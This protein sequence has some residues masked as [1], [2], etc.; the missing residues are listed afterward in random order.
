MILA[1]VFGQAQVMQLEG[2][3]CHGYRGRKGVVTTVTRRREKGQLKL[4]F[5]CSS[6]SR[7]GGGGGVLMLTSGSPESTLVWIRIF[8]MRTSLHTA[9][10]AGSIV[11]PA[12]STDTPVI[13]GDGGPGG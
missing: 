12:R 13:C 8:P 11:S 6:T 3:G 5:F 2:R 1:D 9:L 4:F 7:G 10:R